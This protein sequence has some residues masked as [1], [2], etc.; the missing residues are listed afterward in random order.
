[1]QVTR[2]WWWRPQCCRAPL[3]PASSGPQMKLWI[4]R[5]M[6]QPG[7]HTRLSAAPTARPTII[8]GMAPTAAAAEEAD[9]N[10]YCCIVFGPIPTAHPARSPPDSETAADRG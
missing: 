8:A 10:G 5:R 2:Y 4:V 6:T 3:Q 7:P 9:R 1:M